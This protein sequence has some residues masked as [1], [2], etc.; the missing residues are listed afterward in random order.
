VAWTAPRSHKPRI[1]DDTPDP[2]Y[3]L[4]EDGIDELRAA[5]RLGS[6]EA[7]ALG[8]ALRGL[9]EDHGF[10]TRGSRARLQARFQQR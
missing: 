5:E 10:D 9:L 7:A 4:D 3:F 2:P 8:A 6:A 1:V